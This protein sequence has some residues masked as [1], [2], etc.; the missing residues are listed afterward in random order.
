[1]LERYFKSCTPKFF[2]HIKHLPIGTTAI[3]KNPSY[4]YDYCLRQAQKIQAQTLL[5]KTLWKE[6]VARSKIYFGRTFEEEIEL[7][8][9]GITCQ[10]EGD[11]LE[12]DA[13]WGKCYFKGLF[14]A[15]SFEDKAF[16]KREACYDSHNHR[17]THLSLISLVQVLS[18]G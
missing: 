18:H 14:I 1:M 8:S 7:G 6:D 11:L 13:N 15:T 3:F 2:N 4:F 10:M 12:K 5:L 17:A 16:W 9:E